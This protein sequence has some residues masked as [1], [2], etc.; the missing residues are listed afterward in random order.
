MSRPTPNLLRRWVRRRPYWGLPWLPPNVLPLRPASFAISFAPTTSRAHSLG[1]CRRDSRRNRTATSTSVMPRR[2]RSTS[3]SPTEF[4]GV[5]NLR[6]DDTNPDTEDTSYVDGI[7]AD[8]AWLGFPIDGEPLYASDYFEQLAEWAELLITKGLAYV[9]DQDG[10]TISAP[11]RWL[12]QSRRR[13][14]VPQPLGRR[15]P[16]V[17]PTHASR[18]VRRGL[19]RPASQDRHAAREHADARP[20][21]V[22][23]PWSAPPPN[24]RAVEHL[25]HLR[26]GARPERRHRRRH[27][28]A[29]HPRV[30]Q[31]ST[32]VRLVPRT[33]AAAVRDPAPDRVRSPRTHPHRHVEAQARQARRRRHRRRVGRSP[34]AD[35]AW[36][37]ATRLSGIVDPRVLRLH[38]CVAHQQPSPDRAARVV[39]PDRVEPDCAAAHGGA[40]SGARRHHQLAARRRRSAGGRVGR[41]QQQPGESRRRHPNG[42]VQ[43]D[44]VHRRRRLQGR[45]STEVLPFVTWQ[46][47]SVARRLLRDRHRVRRRRRR[48][49]HRGAGHLRPRDPWWQL[50]P[51][52]A[53]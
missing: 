38:R 11:A 10:E 21:D 53:R 7:I 18:R 35:P 4:G 52:V 33:A 3:A 23:H 45:A 17:V 44:A 15:E 16:R 26:L 22:S 28:L 34:D 43:R 5:C 41:A 48:Q 25:S 9:D 1:G 20:G 46:G 31:S 13:E 32:A 40:A 39:R 14:P 8:L 50:H 6:F 2:S 42:A 47:G 27:P 36:P 19:A 51:T 30:R 24:R 29:V 37:A 49:R 12:R